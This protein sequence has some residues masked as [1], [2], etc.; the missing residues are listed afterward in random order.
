MGFPRGARER[1]M[2]TSWRAHGAPMG[3]PCMRIFKGSLSHEHFMSFVWAIRA[4]WVPTGLP[5]EE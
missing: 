2:K 5:F 4:P 1:G 3:T